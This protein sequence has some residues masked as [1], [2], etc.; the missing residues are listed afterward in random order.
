MS[1]LSKYRSHRINK[2]ETPWTLYYGWFRLSSE[3]GS[4]W[5]I[6]IDFG[7][8][9]SNIDRHNGRNLDW[10]QKVSDYQNLVVDIFKYDIF[11]PSPLLYSFLHLFKYISSYFSSFPD[12]YFTSKPLRSFNL[13]GF[14]LKRSYTVLPRWVLCVFL[15]NL[16]RNSLQTRIASPFCYGYIQFIFF[17]L[18]I[19]IRLDLL[20]GIKRL[21]FETL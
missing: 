2:W 17:K 14:H 19:L 16:F 10:R 20:F 6:H 18:H 12:T 5:S 9:R 13:L 7:L 4:I 15:Y 1:S 21:K 11:F 3:T 8:Y